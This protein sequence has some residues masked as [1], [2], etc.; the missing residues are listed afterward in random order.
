MLKKAAGLEQCLL[1][2]YLYAACSLKSTP[3]EWRTIENQTNLRQA[4]QFERV[5]AWKQSIL[6]VCQEEMIHLHYVQCLLAA[7]GEP[8]CFS[9]PP[10][11]DKG[12]GW[13]VSNWRP[14]DEK[15]TAPL[16]GVTV[17]IRSVDAD[18][19]KQ[20]MLFESSA[21]LQA[22]GFAKNRELFEQLYNCEIELH[23]HV[24]TQQ[25]P[26]SEAQEVRDKLRRLYKE[27]RAF[28]PQTRSFSAGTGEKMS[29]LLDASFASIGEFYLQGIL[30]MYKDAFAKGWVKSDNADMNAEFGGSLASEGFL[31]IQPVPRGRNF[32][33][34]AHENFHGPLRNVM[35]ISNI[36]HEIVAEGEGFED[37]EKRAAAFLEAFKKK[38][39][40][41]G[42]LAAK[43]NGEAWA[44]DGELLRKSH[45]YRFVVIREE[46]TAEASLSHNKFEASR[47]QPE[48]GSL[49]VSLQNLTK[50][51]PL[52]FNAAYLVMLTWLA[53]MYEPRPNPADKGRR[54]AVEMLATWPLMS[55][56]IRPLLELISLF[57]VDLRL[58]YRSDEEYMPEMP[59]HARQ[60]CRLLKTKDPSPQDIDFL[61]VRVL[62]DVGEW[63]ARRLPDVQVIPDAQARSFHKAIALARLTLLARLGEFQQQFTFRLHGGYSN[64]GS[65][66]TDRT[67]K[68]FKSASRFEESP[69]GPLALDP[70]DTWPIYKDA[71]VLRARFAGWGTVQLATDPDP[72]CDEVGCSGTHM[73]HANDDFVLDRTLVWDAANPG[74]IL[75]KIAPHD[76]GVSVVDTSLMVADGKVI[77]GYTPVGIMNSTGAVQ[78]SGVQ[79]ELQIEGLAELAT[80]APKDVSVNLLSTDR[81]K[82]YLHGENHL[83]WKDGE[84]IDPFIFAFQKNTQNIVQR[85]VFNEAGVPMTNFTPIQRL[86]SSRGPCGFADFSIPDWARGQLGDAVTKLVGS[87]NVDEYLADR[88]RLLGKALVESLANIDERNVTQAIVSDVISYAQRMVRLNNPRGTTRGWAT[89]VLNYGHTV[90]GAQSD[91]PDT[92]FF[93]A[94]GMPESLHRS[95]E[96]DRMQANS[97]WLIKYALGIMDT[98]SLRNFVF[99]EVYIPVR[100]DTNAPELKLTWKWTC[101]R[102]LESDIAAFALKW[103]KPFWG[104]YD[105][106][107]AKVRT[108]G[109]EVKEGLVKS[110]D[111]S[112]EYTLDAFGHGC[113]CVLSLAGF[114]LAWT[115]TVRS[116]GAPRAT[117]LFGLLTATAQAADTAIRAQYGPRLSLPTLG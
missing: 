13:F 10:R 8:A 92:P 36:I 47:T 21:S 42:Y 107:D 117:Q 51:L 78:T 93:K 102:A 16:L 99:G 19:L 1:N 81:E 32:D 33:K 69:K 44:Q 74:A 22:D 29:T 30:P 18:F 68:E 110:S 75:R 40:A 24:T 67:A 113:A 70:N 60:L 114:E 5:R 103:E 37:F 3:E 76:V 41:A 83:V 39:G 17:P 54:V 73:L 85:A 82:P 20:L 43:A 2:S 48:L 115:V 56:A 77:A 28:S 25:F 88:V 31:R 91:A 64:V 97:R 80:A 6:A 27:Q 9:L 53:R 35:T 116:P 112:V 58:L 106:I 12:A 26:E 105:H 23:L 50:E 111:K 87:G 108:R 52:N 96:K 45:L 7:L 63:A 100:F 104:A 4:I 65:D 89:T 101:G 109:T 90:S 72:P 46:F 84:P 98:D 62:T 14:N 79:T 66:R 71:L 49:P 15:A 61:A 55:I 38:G 86:L 11:A 34:T 59:F 95:D 57:P 94:L